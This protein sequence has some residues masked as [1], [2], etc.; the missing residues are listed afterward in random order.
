MCEPMVCELSFLNKHHVL[1]VLTYI[2]IDQVLKFIRYSIQ[3]IDVG[4]KACD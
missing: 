2:D 3:V 4:S 1:V